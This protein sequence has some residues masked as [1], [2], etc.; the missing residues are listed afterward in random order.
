MAINANLLP[1]LWLKVYKTAI[2]LKN[3]TP[4]K[5]FS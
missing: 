3:I 2:Y 5:S 1:D 4:K